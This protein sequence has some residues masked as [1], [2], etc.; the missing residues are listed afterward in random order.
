VSKRRSIVRAA[1]LRTAA[2]TRVTM[3]KS[4][5]E[6]PRLQF[7]LAGLLLTVTA[8]A[9]VMAL[10][11]CIPGQVGGPVLILL[12]LVLPALAITGVGNGRPAFRTFCLGALLPLSMMLF[13][14]ALYGQQM[15]AWFSAKNSG[16]SLFIESAAFSRFVGAGILTSIALGYVCIAFRWFLL[17]HQ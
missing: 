7:S 13:Q 10:M 9:G 4:A 2:E 3:G 6:R 8:V 12:A 1:D 14:I 16:H 11:F 5:M 15:V 17:R